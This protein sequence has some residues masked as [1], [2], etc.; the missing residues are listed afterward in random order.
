MYLVRDMD[1]TPSIGLL[2]LTNS[3]DL[4]QKIG[5][6]CKEFANNL[7]RIQQIWLSCTLTAF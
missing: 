5:H 3:Y 1:K 6:V 7:G 2:Y 4:S